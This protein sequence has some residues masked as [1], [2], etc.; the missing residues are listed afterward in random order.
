MKKSGD[1]V[2]TAYAEYSSGPGWAN[3]P[4]WI[5]VR[6]GGDLREECLQPKEQTR[7]MQVLFNICQA[8]N[9]ALTNEVQKFWKKK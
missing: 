6:N 8:A 7:E 3:A 1:Q 5:I 2:V 9:S 4:I